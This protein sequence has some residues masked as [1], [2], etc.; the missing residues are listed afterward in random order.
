MWASQY[1]CWLSTPTQ[2]ETVTD[3]LG[4]VTTNVY[5]A[6]QNLHAGE[7]KGGEGVRNRFLTWRAGCCNLRAWVDQDEPP[8]GTWCIT[9]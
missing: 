1:C 7:E 5:D 2:V 3:P 4:N 8:K 9:S 6:Q